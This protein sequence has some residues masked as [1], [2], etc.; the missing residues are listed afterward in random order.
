[1]EKKKVAIFG[2][3]I[4]GLTVAHEC[5]EAGFEVHLYEKRSFFGGKALGMRDDKGFPIEHAT[6]VYMS[7]YCCFLETMKRISLGDH[8]TAFD[9][10]VPLDG[11]IFSYQK[12]NTYVSLKYADNPIH[13]FFALIKNQRDWGLSW[14]E[15]LQILWVPISFMCRSEE[16]NLDTRWKCSF[17]E[18]HF[19]NKSEKYKEYLETLFN[20]FIAA[21]CHTVSVILDDLMVKFL[22]LTNNPYELPS[23][24]QFTNGPTNEALID[25]WVKH[26]AKLGVHF[27]LSSSVEKL[28]IENDSIQAAVMNNGKEVQADGYVLALP[29]SVTQALTPFLHLPSRVNLE[30]SMGFQIYLNQMPESFSKQKVFVNLQDSPWKLLYLLEGPLLWPTMDYP[31]NVK[32]V[33]SGIIGNCNN[34]GKIYGKSAFACRPEE[35]KEEI[36]A[37]L[38]LD[39]QHVISSFKLDPTIEFLHSSEIDKN[40]KYASWDKGPLFED[41]YRW[42]FESSIFIQKPGDFKHRIP[43]HTSIQNLFLAG[44]YLETSFHI[45]TMERAC[46]SGKRCANKIYQAF[47]LQY[48][49]KRLFRAPMPL[50]W[51]RKIDSFLYRLTKALRPR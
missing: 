20:Q 15:I 28:V 3:G 40:S 46:E 36:F 1:M 32:T 11:I 19:K 29:Y 5:I 13:R 21:R 17:A 42:V 37:Q 25:P 30:W 18:C 49:Q 48:P 6:R 14:L 7:V 27:H 16:R 43:A 24:I 31:Q 2:G 4:A 12:Q 50:G 22:D 35:L 45:P 26:L 10:L 38:G 39:H 44:E 34:P 47:G 9:N 41:G 33:L 23:L 51:I 8:R